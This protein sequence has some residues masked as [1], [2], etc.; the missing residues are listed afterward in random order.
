MSK[1]PECAG[2]RGVQ[3]LSH[4]LF[5]F[6]SHSLTLEPIWWFHMVIHK[7]FEFSQVRWYHMTKFAANFSKISGVFSFFFPPP[8]FSGKSSRCLLFIFCCFPL[9]LSHTCNGLCSVDRQALHGIHAKMATTTPCDANQRIFLW[10]K[11]ATCV[12][13]DR[14]IE[15]KIWWLQSHNLAKRCEWHV[16]YCC[17][18]IHA[19]ASDTCTKDTKTQHNAMCDAI[20]FVCWFCK[21]I[22]KRILLENDACLTTILKFK[23]N[24]RKEV[25]TM[26]TTK[27]NLGGETN[28]RQPQK[29]KTNWENKMS[30]Y[31]LRWPYFPYYLCLGFGFA[32]GGPA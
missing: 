3:S 22:D 8:P 30:P 5:Y 26:P 25:R 20:G 23:L 21:V 14:D 31:I 13:Q 18:N 10:N 32:A 28:P 12:K 19:V 16:A 17:P 4:E 27:R 1:C 29:K 9:T 6:W 24:S 2:S 11:T 7:V 15:T